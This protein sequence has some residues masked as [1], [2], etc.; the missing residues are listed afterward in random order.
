MVL[1]GIS[2]G[3]LQGYAINPARDLGPRVFIA[4]AGFKYNGLI[5]GTGVFWVHRGAND[6]RA[7]RGIRYG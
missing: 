3:A 4:L 2:F 1:I 7:A 6:R 5:D